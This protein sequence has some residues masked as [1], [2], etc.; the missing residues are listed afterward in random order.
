MYTFTIV[1][2]VMLH[3][4]ILT[5]TVKTNKTSNELSTIQYKVGGGID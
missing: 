4:I 2:L 1:N 5:M 3:K